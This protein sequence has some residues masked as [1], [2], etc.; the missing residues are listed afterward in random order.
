[1]ADGRRADFRNSRQNE[2]YLDRWRGI[3]N[4]GRFHLA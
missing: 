4:V 3:A 1:M 2:I